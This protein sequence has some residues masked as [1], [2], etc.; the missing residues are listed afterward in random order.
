MVL[1]LDEYALQNDSYGKLLPYYDKL[2]QFIHE[3]SADEIIK[4]MNRN[5]T[6]GFYSQKAAISRSQGTNF[7][8]CLGYALHKQKRKNSLS[9]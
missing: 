4:E 7:F 5:G 8:L 9:C 3:M 1:H 6:K 2:P